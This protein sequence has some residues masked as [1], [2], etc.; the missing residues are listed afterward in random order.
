MIR[1]TN[2]VSFT[3]RTRERAFAMQEHGHTNE[4]AYAQDARIEL[5]SRAEVA[6]ETKGT[7]TKPRRAFTLPGRQKG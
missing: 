4:L 5:R 2:G 3:K 6:G 1:S 7:G